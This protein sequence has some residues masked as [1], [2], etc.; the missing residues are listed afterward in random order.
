MEGEHLSGWTQL[1]LGTDSMH[2]MLSRLPWE[3]TSSS[4]CTCKMRSP[5]LPSFLSTP[6]PLAHPE[7]WLFPYL[8]R[9]VYFRP[10]VTRHRRRAEP[11]FSFLFLPHLFF[12]LHRLQLGFLVAVLQ[13]LHQDGDN[14]IDQHKLGGEHEGDKVNGRDEGKVGEAMAILWATL[15]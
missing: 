7:M 15:S 9:C 4:T 2:P 12:L 3:H 1:S 8:R 11:P 6:R 5:P 13:V 14:H 10:Q